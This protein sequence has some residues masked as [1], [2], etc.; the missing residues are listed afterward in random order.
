MRGLASPLLLEHTRF[1]GDI[2]QRNN[3]YVVTTPSG[4]D[5]GDVWGCDTPKVGEKSENSGKK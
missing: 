1:I 5:Y 4:V 2:T 3:V